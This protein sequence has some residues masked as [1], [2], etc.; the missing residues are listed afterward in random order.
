TSPPPPTRRAHFGYPWSS[1]L[2]GCPAPIW[3][4]A[5]LPKRYVAAAVP[6]LLGGKGPALPDREQR[7]VDENPRG[8]RTAAPSNHRRGD[9][10]HHVSTRATAPEQRQEAQHH[11]GD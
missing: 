1:L 3:D 4:R 8:E 6:T 2:F 10:L 5:E 11:R 9:P 7:R